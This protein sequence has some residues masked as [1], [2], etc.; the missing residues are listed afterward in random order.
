MIRQNNNKVSNTHKPTLG[1]A[2]KVDR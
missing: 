1:R 2:A